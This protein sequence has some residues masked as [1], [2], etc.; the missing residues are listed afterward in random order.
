MQERPRE[1][2]HRGG[3]LFQTDERPRSFHVT[4]AI[5]R[6]TR[7]IAIELRPRFR[8][9]GGICEHPCATQIHRAQLR[10]EQRGAVVIRRRRRPV[11]MFAMQFAALQVERGVVRRPRDLLRQRGKAHVQIPVSRR[12]ERPRQQADAASEHHASVME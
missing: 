9:P 3:V 11:E 1:I 4:T 7:E 5:V 6:A 8:Q 10:V 12:G 2:R